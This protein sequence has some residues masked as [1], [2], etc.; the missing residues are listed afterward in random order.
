MEQ[1][2]SIQTRTRTAVARDIDRDGLISKSESVIVAVSGGLDSVVLL[3]VLHRLADEDGRSWQ[4]T[5]AHL[6]H[7]L[8]EESAEDARFVEELAERL[9]LE[10]VSERRDVRQVAR[11]RKLGLEEAARQERLGFLQ[12]VAR[13]RAATAVAVGH[14]GDDQVETVL[15][16]LFRGAHLRGLA[17]MAGWRPMGEGVRLVRPLLGLRRD[18]LR[19]YARR[20]GLAWREDPTNAETEMSR[21][22]IRHELLP[23]VRDRLNPRVDEA[24]LRAASAVGEADGLLETLSRSKILRQGEG[25][26][27]LP[28]AGLREAASAVVRRA[29]RDA[30][31]EAGAPMDRL[32]A[33]WLSRLAEL[34]ER[35]EGQCDLPGD[36]RAWVEGDALWVGPGAAWEPFDAFRRELPV[37]QRVRL[38]GG[39]E[40]RTWVE[41]VSSLRPDE[42]L[43]RARREPAGVELF[44]AAAL[45]GTLKVRTRRDGDAFRPIGMDGTQPVADL[46]SGAHLPLRR[47][48]RVLCVCDE[49]GIVSVWPVRMAQ[50]VAVGPRTRR[51]VGLAIGPAEREG[52][53]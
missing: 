6:D 31:V 35:G 51:C 14:H 23:M 21:N 18:Q 5:V 20:G 13:D 39:L 43:E 44:D 10:C 41:D 29:I 46:L 32:G 47:R 27:S 7:A 52:A 48:G 22:W 19:E 28:L 49:E 25:C 24:I 11:R 1:G 34:A 2:N 50:R 30:L 42:L 36:V 17:G 53:Q 33:D 26:V 3:D 45:V 8:R 12:R 37:G 40:A 4:L 16:R 9:N 38:P 15:F